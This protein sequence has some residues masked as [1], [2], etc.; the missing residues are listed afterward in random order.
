MVGPDAEEQ[1]K[2]QPSSVMTMSLPI[3]PYAL[4]GPFHPTLEHG[5]ARAAH[6]HAAQVGLAGRPDIEHLIQVAGGLVRM[7]PDAIGAERHAV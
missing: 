4:A 2:P 3:P 6:W 7:F 1:R 5:A